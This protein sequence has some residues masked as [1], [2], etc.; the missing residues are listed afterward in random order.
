MKNLFYFLR[1]LFRFLISEIKGFIYHQ[2]YIGKWVKMIGI[3]IQLKELKKWR[4]EHPEPT[5]K[6]YSAYLEEKYQ[7]KFTQLKLEDEKIVNGFI[8]RDTGVLD[9]EYIKS[10]LKEKEEAKKSKTKKK[11]K[12]TKKED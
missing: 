7:T 3:K 4:K 1:Y 12:N 2:L 8:I 6:D 9:E 10:K 5:E 11:K